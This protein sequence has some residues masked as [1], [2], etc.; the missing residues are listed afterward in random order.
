MLNT[1]S[2]FLEDF[3]C[4]DCNSNIV[5]CQSNEKDYFYYCSQKKCKN[6]VGEEKFDQDDFADFIVKNLDGK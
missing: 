5:V 4:R 1:D 6:H 3:R 2:W